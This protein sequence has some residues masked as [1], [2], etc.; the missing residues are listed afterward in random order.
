MRTLKTYSKKIKSKR[1]RTKRNVLHGNDR[2]IEVRTDYSF[3]LYEIQSLSVRTE[4]TEYN[5]YNTELTLLFNDN[6]LYNHI[7]SNNIS[8]KANL[9][10]RGTQYIGCFVKEYNINLNNEIEIIMSVDYSVINY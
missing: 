8:S 6:T 1:G 7:L 4:R 5:R 9:T 3:G 2:L 10:F